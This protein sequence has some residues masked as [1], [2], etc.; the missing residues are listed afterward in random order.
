MNSV[1]PLR[2]FFPRLCA[3]LRPGG[4]PEGL[5]AT[6][7]FLTLVIIRWHRVSQPEITVRVKGFALQT[8]KVNTGFKEGPNSTLP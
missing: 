2:W 4:L 7:C 5:I 6:E 3:S 8:C 1:G